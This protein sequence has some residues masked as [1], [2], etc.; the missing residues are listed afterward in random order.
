[1]EMKGMAKLGGKRERKKSRE[2]TWRGERSK[3][4]R[5]K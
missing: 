5:E 1:M 4:R 3:Q 2:R